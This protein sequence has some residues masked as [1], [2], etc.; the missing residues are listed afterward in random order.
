MIGQIFK[1]NWLWIITTYS[2]LLIE[3]VIFALAPYLLGKAVD[4]VLGQSYQDFWIYLGALI[5]GLVIGFGRRV[6]DTRAFMRV[7]CGAAID[8]VKKLLA[9]GHHTA[10]IINRSD[11]VWRYVTFF[12]G[13]LPRTAAC[14]VDITVAL[15]M[16][17]IVIPY[18]GSI[19]TIL[20]ILA[21]LISYRLACWSKTVDVKM[22]AAREKVNHAIED[23][24]MAGVESGYQELRKHQVRV[25]DINA[26]NWGSVDVVE[27]TAKVMIIFA[28]AQQGHTVG[29]IMAT[30]AYGLRLF[31]RVGVL[32]YSF[33]DIKEIEVANDLTQGDE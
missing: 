22:Q 2:L 32:T 20:T 5:L 12:E 33:M 28:L 16:I 29:T 19:V 21:L 24:D 9:R 30:I 7:W 3:L 4:A 14:I 6:F 15:V 23:K 10:V 26:L 1:R 13:T 18:T 8:T 25:S 27:V 17:F 11:L 31:T